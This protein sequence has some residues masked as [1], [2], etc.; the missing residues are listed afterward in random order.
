MRSVFYYLC[1]YLFSFK[2]IQEFR[3]ERIYKLKESHPYYDQVQGQLFVTNKHACDFVVWTP[4]DIAIVRIP[5]DLVWQ[6]NI[7]VLTD[8]YF[9]K[10]MPHLQQLYFVLLLF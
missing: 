1:I 9:H 3:G 5:Q 10:F 7:S 4:K 6:R 8:F 2:E